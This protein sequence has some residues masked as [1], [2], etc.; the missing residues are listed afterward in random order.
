MDN[1]DLRIVG[2]GLRMVFAGQ[3]MALLSL[4]PP[5]AV[6]GIVGLAAV[7]GGLS[8]ASKGEDGYKPAVT[9]SVLNWL[10]IF[11]WAAFF[12]GNYVADILFGTISTLLGILTVYYV[13][14]VT[15]GLFT[16][17][18]E[19]LAKGGEVWKPYAGGCLLVQVCYILANLPILGGAAQYLM[20]GSVV[21]QVAVTLLY[22]VFLH[23]SYR[24]F[25][26]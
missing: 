2:V 12:S 24:Y 19:S 17:R 1:K 21:V 7:L 23:Q 22:L 18:N 8:S 14:T 5:L 20:I 9:L 25:M 15:A 26:A 3:L 13:C 4:I 11:L 6:A 16:N 10:V